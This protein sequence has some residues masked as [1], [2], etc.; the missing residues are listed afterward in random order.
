MAHWEPVSK[1]LLTSVLASIGDPDGTRTVAAIVALLVAIGVALA[2]LAVWIFRSTRPDPELLA[3]LEVMGE[4]A[5]RRS[6]PVWQRRR[7]DEVRPAG[8]TPLV[9]SAAPPQLDAA[10]DAGPPATGF[11]DL[12]PSAADLASSSVPIDDAQ[13]SVPASVS[14]ADL[15][16]ASEPVPVPSEGASDTAAESTEHVADAED[17][18][19]PE[20]IPG[21]DD[22]PFAAAP[23]P[24]SPA[25][26]VDATPLG[27][28]WPSLDDLPEADLDPEVLAAAQ[29]ELDREL[30]ETSGSGD[31]DARQRSEQLDLFG[32]DA[33]A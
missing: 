6:D 1:I 33:E 21:P 19:T 31:G 10:F 2:A 28:A 23:T 14:V 29:A 22:A 26:P 16:A 11:D 4:R 17:Q 25:E 8:A 27:G 20:P 13:A 15:V 30:A 9:P 7:L 24:E 32:S 12:R 5:W 18:P 3:P